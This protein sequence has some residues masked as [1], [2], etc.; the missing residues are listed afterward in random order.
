MRATHAP[1]FNFIPLLL[2]YVRGSRQTLEEQI[3][4]YFY[5][6]GDP[7]VETL[8]ES[9]NAPRLIVLCFG[10]RLLTSTEP[11]TPEIHAPNRVGAK[12]L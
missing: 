12:T 10:P 2:L 11:I 9:E 7:P 4:R 8:G 6:I 1:C 3:T 5:D